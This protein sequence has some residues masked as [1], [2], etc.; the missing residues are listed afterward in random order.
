MLNA[1]KLEVNRLRNLL[2]QQWKEYKKK[3][4]NV[5]KSRLSKSSLV[6]LLPKVTKFL[7]VFQHLV[8]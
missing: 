2:M 4:Q 1:K 3:K 7:G 6:A 8:P 5:R